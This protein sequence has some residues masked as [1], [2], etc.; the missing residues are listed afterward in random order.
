MRVD[1]PDNGSTMMA[2]V[3]R[4]C[5]VT[6]HSN[7]WSLHLGLLPLASHLSPLLSLYRSAVKSMSDL[8]TMLV[9]TESSHRPAQMIDC[10][11]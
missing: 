7:L 11:M 10:D 1:L 4:H 2:G 6:H 8:P 5:R 3:A 9:A